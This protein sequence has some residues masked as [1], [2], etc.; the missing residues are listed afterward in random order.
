MTVIA[1]PSRIDLTVSSA[2][3]VGAERSGLPTA[4][5]IFPISSFPACRTIPYRNGRGK[6]V[7]RSALGELHAPVD[8]RVVAAPD[9]QQD[10]GLAG[11]AR[12]I[13]DRGRFLGRSGDPL[14]DREDD[15]AG[16]DV[17][18]GGIAR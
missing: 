4:L 10:R 12:R 13:H 14:V 1:A 8:G 5:P 2:T 7:K 6:P 18:G 11:T 15:V 16:T 17:L 9:E 3:R